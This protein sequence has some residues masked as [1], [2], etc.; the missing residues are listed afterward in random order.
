MNEKQIIQESANRNLCALI[1]LI[2]IFTAA[3][4]SSIALPQ[5]GQAGTAKSPAKAKTKEKAEPK[6]SGELQAL[7]ADMFEKAK[8]LVSSHKFSQAEQLLGELTSAHPDDARI[9]LLYGDLLEQLGRLDEASKEYERVAELDT[10]DPIPTINLARISLR[11]LE[12]EMSLSYAQQAVARDPSYL[13]GRITLI[14]TLIACDQTGEAERQIKFISEKDKN[15]KSVQKLAYK[16][17]LK[18]GDFNGAH[19]HLMNINQREQAE[20]VQK[21]SP[22]NAETLSLSE[23]KDDPIENVLSAN[24]TISALEEIDLLETLGNYEQARKKLEDIISADSDSDTFEAR[25]KLARLLE[26]RF[27]DY[28][29]AL[30]NFNEALVID[31]LSATAI[32]GRDRCKAKRRNLALQLKIWFREL[33]AQQ[34][35]NEK[36]AISSKR[37]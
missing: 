25:L 11:Q 17:A 4:P 8:T 28:D 16:L 15:K 27:H 31:P 12:L 23:G 6:I 24:N 14:E 13:P 32:A 20:L 22:K 34:Q 7:N 9:H 21:G 30:N 2:L 26:S 3:L 36:R 10:S 19:Q 1:S 35:L 29:E 5:Q 33:W 37:K 18:K